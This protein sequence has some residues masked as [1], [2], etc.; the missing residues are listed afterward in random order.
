[1]RIEK[2]ET[3][4]PVEFPD[5]AFIRYGTPS[6]RTN[7]SGRYSMLWYDTEAEAREIAGRWGGNGSGKIVKKVTYEIYAFGEGW[8]KSSKY[9]YEEELEKVITFD[10]EGMKRKQRFDFLNNCKHE[11]TRE[12]RQGAGCQTWTDRYCNDCGQAC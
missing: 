9:E 7:N 12:V 1:M 8:H 10:A 4:K 3:L 6:F 11:D 2:D 5:D